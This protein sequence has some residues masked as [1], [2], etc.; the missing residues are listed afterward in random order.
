MV[1]VNYMKSPTLY[2]PA[3]RELLDLDS[4]RRI[5]VGDDPAYTA[6]SIEVEFAVITT[7]TAPEIAL[8]L[9]RRFAVTC[10]HP[11]VGYAFHT[12]NGG[13]IL[14]PDGTYAATGWRASYELPGRVDDFASV[15]LGSRSTGPLGAMRL[16]IKVCEAAGSRR[17]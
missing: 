7:S 3:Y 13:G 14:R 1:L 4:I 6:R 9:V 2:L 10:N 12:L 15:E 16:A 5:R 11:R 8:T 17:P